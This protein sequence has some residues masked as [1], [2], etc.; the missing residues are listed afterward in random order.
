MY[1]SGTCGIFRMVDLLRRNGKAGILFFFYLVLMQYLRYQRGRSQ[2][3]DDQHFQS[4][5]L[6][7]DH[8]PAVSGKF[9]LVIS[10]IVEVAPERRFQRGLSVAWKQ[11]VGTCDC[12][13]YTLSQR[14][15]RQGRQQQKNSAEC[16]GV[17]FPLRHQL[18]TRTCYQRK[19]FGARTW[20][21]RSV[22]ARAIGRLWPPSAE[23]RHRAARY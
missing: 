12:S 2:Q 6:G 4:I 16:H 1:L 20:I 13:D 21:L 5:R 14:R 22:V 23:W 19:A 17:T 18:A 10:V 3:V 11:P 15:R 8:L 7:Q 9:R